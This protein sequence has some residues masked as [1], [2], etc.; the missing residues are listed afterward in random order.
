MTDLSTDCVTITPTAIQNKIKF[1]KDYNSCPQGSFMVQFY[2][3]STAT[4]CAAKWLWDFGDGTTSTVESPSHVYSAPFNNPYTVKLT[5]FVP[6]GPTLS[7]TQQINLY[8]WEPE[9]TFNVCTDGHIIYDTGAPNPSWTFLDGTPP[10]ATDSH[11]RICYKKSG[12]KTVKLYAINADDGYCEVVRDLN[13]LDEN[14][15]R[16]CPRDST[17]EVFEFDYKGKSYRLLTLL[18]CY[19]FPH[20]VVFAR[21]KLQV[22]GKWGWRRKWGKEQELR[23]DLS[24]NLYTKKANG[25]HCSIG[26][27]VSGSKQVLKLARVTKRFMPPL[28]S[29][30]RMREGD[31]VSTHFVMIDAGDLVDDGAGNMEVRRFTLS[32]WKHNCGCS[33]T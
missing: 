1:R 26:H 5:M 4:S 18:R 30:T 11:I 28:I 27:P 3:E 12:P 8:H 20:P 14:F 13:M 2:N 17:R 24:G 9:F 7:T 32:L 19:G 23:I 10:T 33:P 31:V 16:C 15:S 21:S 22:K 6:S 29:R 25:C